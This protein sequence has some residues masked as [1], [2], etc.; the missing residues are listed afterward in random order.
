MLPHFLKNIVHFLW[1][2]IETAL[3]VGHRRNGETACYAGDRNRLSVQ[4]VV[5]QT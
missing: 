5:M 3:L 1:N 2:M 4:I